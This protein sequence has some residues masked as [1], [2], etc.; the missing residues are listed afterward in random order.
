MFEKRITFTACQRL[1]PLTLTATVEALDFTI[2]APT[3]ARATAFRAID[4]VSRCRLGG[5]HA[6]PRRAILL[7][8]QMDLRYAGSLFLLRRTAMTFGLRSRW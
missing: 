6:A 1:F 2:K 3:V 4:G 7:A 5:V 8:G